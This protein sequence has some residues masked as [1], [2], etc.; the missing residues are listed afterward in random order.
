MLI[1]GVISVRSRDIECPIIGV[2]SC[3]FK[4]VFEAV[5]G[6]LHRSSDYIST[7]SFGSSS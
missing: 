1:N 4:A 7:V 3:K 5:N 2:V 6:V